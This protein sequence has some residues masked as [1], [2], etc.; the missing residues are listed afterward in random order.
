[1]RRPSPAFVIAC[2]ALFAALSGTGY[3][4]TKLATNSV[5]TVQLQRNAVVSSKIANGT[6]GPKEFASSVRGTKGATGDIGATG[7][8]T[9]GFTLSYDPQAFS[10]DETIL[11][12]T[13]EVPSSGFLNLRLLIFVSGLSVGSDYF[14][15]GTTSTLTLRQDGRATSLDSVHYPDGVTAIMYRRQIQVA[16]SAGDHVFR[17]QMTCDNGSIPT[18]LT[19]SPVMHGSFGGLLVK[20][21]LVT[22]TS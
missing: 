1:M 5:G 20:E 22:A 18:N 17:I 16:A 4:A 8:A 7:N 6:L 3:A 14:C 19:P 10:T 9:S 21:Q 13:V 15:P 2:I 12:Q 11:A